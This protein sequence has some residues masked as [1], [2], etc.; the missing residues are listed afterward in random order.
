MLLTRRCLLLLPLALLWLPHALL[1]QAPK[2]EVRPGKVAWVGGVKYEP[3]RLLVKF[4]PGA[5]L[6]SKAAA[7]S[8]VQ[9][10]VVHEFRSIRNLQLVYLPKGLQVADA[11]RQ[12]RQDPNV[13]YAEPDYKVKSFGTPNDPFFPQQWSLSN[14]GTNGGTTGADI[15]ALAA[16]GLTTGSSQVVVAVIDSG[17]DYQH[18]DLA[19]NMWTNAADCNNDGIDDDGNGY[20]DD[21]H[22][23]DVTNPFMPTVN[24]FDELG[25]GTHVAGTI[26]ATGNN[27]TGVTGINWNVQILPC[28]FLGNSALAGSTS[29]AILCLDYVL[30]MKNHGVNIVATNNSWGGSGYSQALYDAIKAQEDAGIL[31]IAAAGNDFADNDQVPVYPAN[32]ALPNVISVAATTN[33]DA[34]ATFSNLGRHTVALGAPGQEILST[35]PNNTYSVL[36]GTSMA[37]P[38]VTGVVALLK[39]QDPTRDWRAI[40][41]L[42][43]A[44]GHPDPALANTITG[45]RLDAYGAMTC[46]GQTQLQRLTPALSQIAGS[47]GAPVTFSMLNIQCGAPNGSLTAA[48]QPGNVTIDLVDDGTGG[49]I[50]AGD[51]IFT[52][53]WTPSQ[54]GSYTVQ[55]PNG[56]TVAVQVLHNYT[57]ASETY[58]YVSITG[59]SLDLSDDSVATVASP[60]PIQYGNG[61]FNNVYVGSNGILSFTDQI[62]S[63]DNLPVPFLSYLP[64]NQVV[65]AVAPF[66]DDL[67]PVPG[68]AQN[69]YWDVVGTAP[70]RQLV[71]EWRNVRAFDCLTDSNAT[72]T[73]EAVFNENSPDFYFN[74]ADA[75]FGD[76]CSTHDRGLSATVGMQIAP[77]PVGHGVGY[78][79]SNNGQAVNDQ[80]TLHWRLVVAPPPTNPVPTISSITPSSLLLDATTDQTI[81]INGTNFVPTSRM[82]WNG[83]V[84]L[85]TT[86]V[87]ST[88]VKVIYPAQFLGPFAG[89][90]YLSVVNPPPG[91]G[92]SYQV[93]YPL[94]APTPRIMALPTT[95]TA[96]GGFG[97]TLEV[98]GSDFV[99]STV[100]YWNGQPLSSGVYNAGQLFA[101]IPA[102]YLASPGMAT[103]TVSSGS[104]TG[105]SNPLTFTIG[106]PGS[107]PAGI[108]MAT[109]PPLRL[110]S[111]ALPPPPRKGKEAY[112]KFLGWNLAQKLGPDYLKRFVR[113]NAWAA[114]TEHI[115]S[116]ALANLSRQIAG[117]DAATPTPVAPVL[118]DRLPTD[119]LPES[120]ATGDFNGDGNQDWVVANAGANSLWIYLGHGDGTADPPRVIQLRGQTPIVVLTADLRKTGVLDLIVAEPDSGTV[121]VLLGN[122]DGTFQRERLIFVPGPP[123]SMVAGD[124]NGDGNIDVVVGVFTESLLVGP[125]VMLPGDGTGNF[126]APV[127]NPYQFDGTLDVYALA[128]ADFDKDGHP[129]LAVVSFDPIP[130]TLVYHN[131]GNGRFKQLPQE[132]APGLT[133]AAGDVDG[134]G[135]PDVIVG[136]VFFINDLLPYMA[137]EHGNCDGTFGSS[138]A[139]GPGGF[140][141]AISLTDINGDGNPDIVT[142]SL[143]VGTVF[144]A[145]DDSGDVLSVLLGDGKGHFQ[146][147]RV[148]RGS[149]T[150][151]GLA[152]ADLNKDGHLDV[153]TANQDSDSAV[154]FLND[155][156]GGFGDPQGKYVGYQT[157]DSG[158]P[159]NAPYPPN[160]GPYPVDV[161]GDGFKDLAFLE[162]GNGNPG[163]FKVAVMLNDGTGHFTGPVRTPV[164]DVSFTI[165]DYTF[166]DFRNTGKPDFLAIGSI[167]S[168]GA[169]GI[170]FAPNSGGGNFGASTF[171][172]PPNT[173]GI[174]GVGDFNGDGKLDFVVAGPGNG[175][176]L[177]SLTT[178][179]GNGD[180][181]FHQ[182]AQQFFGNPDYRWPAAVWVGDFN[183]DG[184]L[185]VLVWMYINMEPIAEPLFEFLGNGDGTFQPARLLFNNMG[186]M[187]LADINHDGR[188]DIVESTSVVL[189]YPNPTPPGF[190][191]YL[192]QS[193]GTFTLTN[194]YQP[195]AHQTKPPFYGATN[196]GGHYAS[197]LADFNG[198]GNVDIAAF[199]QV[200]NP[201]LG[202]QPLSFVQFLLGN[203][204]GTFT[205]TYNVY[206]FFKWTTP[207]T[208]ADVTNSGRASL[209]EMDGLTSAYQVIPLGPAPGLQAALVADPVIGVNGTVRITMN[210]ASASTRTVTL[211]TSDPNITITPSVDI[212]AG[213]LQQDVAFQ[214]GAGF[215]PSHTFN[216]AAQLG[217]DKAIAYGS[218][219]LPGRNAGFALSPPTGLVLDPS[220]TSQT[221]GGWLYVTS[222]N[223]YQTTVTVQCPNPPSGVTCQFDTSTLTLQPGGFAAARL[224]F[225]FTG[226]I[227]PQDLSVDVSATDP[228]VTVTSAATF[229]L[230]NPV[231]TITSLSPKGALLGS[232]DTPVTITGTGFVSNATV[233]FGTASLHPFN[234]TGT[235]MTVTV[236][237]AQF[238]SPGNLNVY[239][240]NPMPGG[241]TSSPA[242]FLVQ[243]VS[244]PGLLFVPVTPCRV[245]DT[246]NANGTFGGPAIFGGNTRGFPIPSSACNIPSTAQAFAL[247]V[248]VVP[249]GQLGYLTMY[250]CDQNLPFVSTLNSLDGR[251]KAVGAIVP[252][253]GPRNGGAVCAFA[254][255]TTDLVLDIN[256]YFVP[257]GGPAGLAFY[258]VTP[259]RLVDTRLAAGP[260]GGPSLVGNATRTF[261]LLTSSCGIPPAA[262]AYSLNFTSVP[263]GSLGYLT[264]WPAGQTQPFV[265]TLNALTGTITA[266][267][268][269]VPAGTNGDVSVFATNN[270]DLVI[271][272]NGYF[273]PPTATGLS[274]TNLPP[275]RALDTRAQNAPPFSGKRDVDIAGSACG[276]SKTA[277]AF[278]LNATV[279]PSGGLGY[280]TLWP[281]GGTQPFVSTLNATDGAITSNMA[282]VPTTNGSVSAYANSATHLVLD[283]AAYFEGAVP[284]DPTTSTASVTPANV[285]HD[286]TKPVQTPALLRHGSDDFA[287]AVGALGD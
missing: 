16:W 256:G 214:I 145:G 146:P 186:Y 117:Q 60:F 126:G 244:G 173:Q 230:L 191:T 248:T 154:V 47:V 104:G 167:F 136:P 175:T 161:N 164:Y 147:A 18:P 233:N 88:Q 262:Q 284:L 123:L 183:G 199:Q 218:V 278:V 109:S 238:T 232:G 156:N 158:G 209:I 207:I 127:Y 250:P 90:P 282:I 159:T 190:R 281:Q 72:I 195:Y 268:A 94:N 73:F 98:D 260:L 137:L 196:F 6:K 57:V 215:D 119:Y 178:F 27:G 235:Q 131:D 26:G 32:F 267:A 138:T 172:T 286:A 220:K 81:T 166:A 236:P 116:L 203:G 179:S 247:N 19:A 287:L 105:F 130:V 211:T 45:N 221:V 150:A 255:N 208:A 223:G 12:Y 25:H 101:T 37:A 13:E 229:V 177:G 182:A 169:P 170:V 50:A 92:R 269:I 44:G 200:P 185:D 56:D 111:S 162:W 103:I 74:Y 224:S 283:I 86:Y 148:Y 277:Q 124:F 245:V 181:T 46:S 38:H 217:G 115:S 187:Q 263:Q 212:P 118:K 52:G 95:S 198:D 14:T 17:V 240:V 5:S 257:A 274:L 67:Y 270:S 157:G 273:A 22:G 75:I 271:D 143:L 128:A 29:G 83:S 272:V 59:T 149:V 108:G 114:S 226:P 133:V 202:G 113:N 142:S 135:C 41:N 160:T 43:L 134:D 242:S 106:P 79:W 4:R 279:V 77:A 84:D 254:S 97:I 153:V 62:T 213:G 110:P 174:L 251:I 69:V 234:V 275:C 266:N 76:A 78:Q 129:D 99:G 193:D 259:C 252:A 20:I 206:P 2:L 184:K 155:G 24:M 216:I 197:W 204:D 125:L 65:T 139:L 102:S 112:L 189:D 265:S 70:N 89:S 55:F 140:P 61:T 285:G 10:T 48:V 21:C 249:H 144:G 276:A 219:A 201:V 71:I 152:T 34:A 180:G 35:T 63:F 264:V 51:G 23:I 151:Y 228:A 96:A 210:Q 246:R 1:A 243:G 49:D 231:P 91:G 33:T 11:A 40:K 258:P 42:I 192:G 80:M 121:G 163:P 85:L 87:S 165:G 168:T 58:Q 9:G 241:G 64:G 28:K 8:R 132:L 237:A 3:G 68:S 239:V 53:Q 39:A 122:G 253:G 36:S 227:T 30:W 176:Y 120:V 280:V 107:V 82:Q 31:F 225:T 93:Y 222:I 261:P 54:E 194:T 100:A 7:H 188:L 141:I 205:P 66:W 15:N 171:T